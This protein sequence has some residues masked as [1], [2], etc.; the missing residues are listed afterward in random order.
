MKELKIHW[1]KS[2]YGTG[3]PQIDDQHKEL[4]ERINSFLDSV[5]RGVG[6]DEIENLLIFLENYIKSHFLCEERIMTERKC[7]ACVDNKAAHARFIQ[8]YTKLRNLYANNRAT[9]PFLEEMAYFLLTWWRDHIAKV[10]TKLRD[11]VTDP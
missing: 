11:T 2:L 5:D 8:E 4:F 1:V 10:D 6:K 3:I 7:S 9:N